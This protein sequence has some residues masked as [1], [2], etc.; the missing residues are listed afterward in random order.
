MSLLIKKIL[1]SI[2]NIY[3]KIDTVNEKIRDS[4]W[5]TAVLTEDFKP[6]SNDNSNMP[7]YRRIGNQVQIIGSVSPMET[8]PG[9]T[10]PYTIFTLPEGYRPSNPNCYT[11]CHGS[12]KNTWLL[13]VQSTGEVTFSRYGVTSNIDA[14]N[15]VWL[16]FDHTFFVD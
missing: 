6:Y 15:N 7:R 1:S 8:I 16:I 4:G 10:T 12:R 2:K 3:A 9:S 14:E 11:I 5:Q 13:R